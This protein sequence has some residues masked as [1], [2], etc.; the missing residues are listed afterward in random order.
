MT[1]TST[2]L[3]GEETRGSKELSD[4]LAVA[5][6]EAGGRRRVSSQRLGPLSL[7]HRLLRSTGEA[8]GGAGVPICLGYGTCSP[9]LSQPQ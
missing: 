9:T 5:H 3:T 4:L 8:G 2:H 6:L 1:L 7:D